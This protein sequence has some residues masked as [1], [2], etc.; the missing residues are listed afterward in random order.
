MDLGIDLLRQNC[1]NVLQNVTAAQRAQ[2][3][4]QKHVCF[5]LF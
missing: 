1:D 2:N 4:R 5:C 3:R